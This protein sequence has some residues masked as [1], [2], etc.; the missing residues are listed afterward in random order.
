MI[1]IKSEKLLPI[2][3]VPKWCEQT[4]EKRVSM[5]T[6]YRW[7]LRGIR[8]VKLETILIGGQRYTSYTRLTDFFTRSTD[9]AESK[10]VEKEVI[11]PDTK[12]VS[13]A[14]QA[15]ADAGM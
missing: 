11:L 14:E 4:F 10:P 3:D 12:N 15:L 5:S 1:C 8:G 13:S 9:A 2:K 7:H 6:I